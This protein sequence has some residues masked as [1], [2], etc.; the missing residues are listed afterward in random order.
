MTY[1]TRIKQAREEMFL[2]Q[3]QLAEELDISRQAV[4]KWEA[5]L[6][7]PTR[8]KLER[9]SE[10]LNI[11]P[12]TWAEID[13]E[14]A[15]AN[16]LPDSARPWKIATAVLAVVCVI[17]AVCL[18][19]SLLPKKESV[20]DGLAHQDKAEPPEG[21][22]PSEGT[23]S[24]E[25]DSSP[26]L[27]DS[28]LLSARH[29]YTFGDWNM[30]LY[31]P[32]EIP[33]LDDGEQVM[34]SELWCDWF[35]DGT[36]LSL[37]P[38][39]IGLYDEYD[40]LHEYTNLY[41]LYAPPVETTGGRLEYHILYRIG[42]D[43]TGGDL[44]DPDAA[45]F[46]NVLGYDGFKITLS[47][48][49]NLYRDCAY[50]TQGPDGLPRMMCIQSDTAREVDVDD[51]GELEFVTFNSE[52]LR[53]EITDIPNGE[54][55]AYIY[56]VYNVYLN[57]PSGYIFSCDANRGGF[58]IT[59][60]ANTI[61]SRCVLRDDAL[62]RIPA[63][64]FTVADYPDVGGTKITFI[65]DSSRIGIL[66]D[67][68]DPDMILPY[69]PGLRISHRQQAYIALQELYN[70]TGLKV[71]SCYCA[72]NEFGVLLS[73]LSDGFNDRSFFS[74][75]FGEDH[76]GSGIPSFYIS[77]KELD[78]DWSPLS[79]SESRRPE[80][81]DFS[82]K[83]ASYYDRLRVFNTGEIEENN[84][85]EPDPESEQYGYVGEGE[86]Y[87]SDGSLYVANYLTRDE[88]PVLISL[89]GPYPDGVANH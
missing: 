78:H 33:F 25:E 23:E 73:L 79:F 88:D 26:V 85:S 63:T 24:P 10:I 86:F 58:V 28:V 13:A 48:A 70:L 38:V 64:D 17:L 16:A 74:A 57:I 50:I 20:P 71:D 45:A 32:A 8:D 6:S 1:G 42:E 89:V 14:L 82:Q 40:M 39:T 41:L 67:G 75:Y 5:D 54:E 77:W 27:F 76:G 84:C 35:P 53:W 2:T 51:D 21:T 4:S 7:R 49:K 56:T 81:E 47:H 31:D 72:A 29:D 69:N 34:D 87:L 80:G 66:T 18:T 12:E 3:E 68:L 44:G 61:I 37:V 62:V 11:P 83:I 22:E 52:W 36:R 65:T 30:G 43:Y 60:A 19:A 15:A 46:T 55:G 9:L 59:D